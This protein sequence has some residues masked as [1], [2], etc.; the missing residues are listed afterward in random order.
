MVFSGFESINMNEIVDQL[1]A[2]DT[3]D[4]EIM[5]TKLRNLPFVQSIIT[6]GDRTDEFR[7][8]FAINSK[9]Q[10][11]TTPEELSSCLCIGRNTAERTLKSTTHHYITIT[12][13]LTKMFCTNKAHLRYT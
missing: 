9:R 7:Y 13:L 5:P 12:G 4:Y 2:Y 1:K 10:Y 6:H 11:N 3:V 8:I